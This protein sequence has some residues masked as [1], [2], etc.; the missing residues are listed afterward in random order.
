YAATAAIY[1][2]R[3]DRDRAGV[4]RFALSDYLVGLAGLKGE[5]PPGDPFIT[6]VA[7]I[8]GLSEDI[9]RRH[10]GR[11]PR[12][13]FA[14]EIRRAAGEVVSLYDSTVTRPARPDEREDDGTD[15]VLQPAVAA[16][17][18]AFN[19]Y[20][21]DALGYRTDLAYRVL[22]PEISRQWNWQNERQGGGLG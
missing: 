22:P 15:P 19:A 4:E 16:Y 21:A 18:A 7:D 2:P 11:I 12:H 5:P 1:A 8:A 6:K 20:A 9:V 13:V 14:H 17:G 3:P 10:R